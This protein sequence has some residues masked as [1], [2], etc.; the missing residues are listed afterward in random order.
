MRTTLAAACVFLSCL[1]AGAMAQSPPGV[2][3]QAGGLNCIARLED[4]AR[5]ADRTSLEC[6]FRPM[7]SE[8]DRLRYSGE[9]VGSGLWLVDPG[10][11]RLFWR[12]LAPTRKLDARAL[13]GDYDITSRNDFKLAENGHNVLFGGDADAI[14]LQL[15]APVVDGIRPSTRM[16]L[17]L[18]ASEGR[19]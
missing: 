13:E 4:D 7:G 18:E 2:L 6:E 5:S 11:V 8:V 17:R 12:V 16:T 10:P 3:E 9:L 1:S 14:A 19:G 15:N